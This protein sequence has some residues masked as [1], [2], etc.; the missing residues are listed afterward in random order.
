MTKLF[1]LTAISAFTALAM[2][3]VA[4][5]FA[6][7]YHVK[8]C[9]ENE[10]CKTSSV[11][12]TYEGSTKEFLVE[13]EKEKV[14]NKCSLSLKNKVGDPT[15]EKKG[16]NIELSVTGVKLSECTTSAIEPLGLPWVAAFDAPEYESTGDYEREKFELKTWFGNCVYNLES[17]LLAHY[18]L[19]QTSVVNR[20]EYTKVKGVLGLEGEPGIFC[21]SLYRFKFTVSVNLI[22]DPGLPGAAYMEIS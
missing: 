16:D 12:T 18:V 21:S 5:A 8:T 1:A 9:M 20:V 4:P 13:D 14:I 15:T 10:E 19:E 7:T 2:G 3:V 17:G 22:S 6:T 11:G